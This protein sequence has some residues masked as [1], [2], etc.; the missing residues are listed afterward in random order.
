MIFPYSPIFKKIPLNKVHLILN[1]WYNK[2]LNVFGKIYL[3]LFWFPEVTA[4]KRIVFLK[5]FIK[6]NFTSGNTI[7]DAGCWRGF[8]SLTFADRF[9]D[10]TFIWIE[11]FKNSY[12]KAVELKKILH[13][14]NVEFYNNTL[15][16]ISN[17]KN[18]SV[19][20]I[21][22]TEIL[23]HI[24]DDISVLK[25]FHRVLKKWWKILITV[26]KR[27][28]YLTE[29]QY[30]ELKYHKP[31]A[32]VRSGYSR[33][34]F[35]EKIENVGFTFVSHKT[36]YKLFHYMAVK[37]EQFFVMRGMWYIWIILFPLLRLL[38][39]LDIISPRFFYYRGN[40]FIIQK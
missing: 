26:P 33:E 25:E 7:L 30:H 5:K 34:E 19:D 1:F 17:I 24:E 8:Y 21:Y 12:E 3:I 29:K 31:F 18:D 16:D 4:H 39:L 32:H 27:E 28:S 13:L 11:P 2:I 36:Y 14:H 38:S 22:C 23:E 15:E 40:I 37:I 35:Q 20:G 10:K 9:N 6:K